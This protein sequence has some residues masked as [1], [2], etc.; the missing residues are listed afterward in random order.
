MRHA[1]ELRASIG[2]RVETPVPLCVANRVDISVGARIEEPQ[3]RPC[4]HSP[5]VVL[6]NPADRDWADEPKSMFVRDERVIGSILGPKALLLG[7]K[8]RL[9]G[10]EAQTRD[11]F[12]QFN[13]GPS[14]RIAL[15]GAF[16]LQVVDRPRLDSDNG[17][18][19][20]LAGIIDDFDPHLT[21]GGAASSA[22]LLWTPESRLWPLWDRPPRF[23]LSA[24]ISAPAA[25]RFLVGD[26]IGFLERS[27]N[28]PSSDSS[29]YSLARIRPC[30]S[31][32]TQAGTLEIA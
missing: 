21:V 8:T 20:R 11:G 23:A 18:R 24:W 9:G 17:I 15:V 19:H 22:R 25:F 2:A 14:M 30:G 12:G 27:F 6:H 1:I 3:P 28:F 4:N 13:G 31:I 7:T 5:L 29:E 10:G 16:I 26:V 32:N